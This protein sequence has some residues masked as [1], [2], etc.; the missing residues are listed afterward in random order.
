MIQ[1]CNRAV[2]IHRE[3]GATEFFQS[4]TLQKKIE[5]SCRAAGL[6]ETW[7]AEDI[8]LSVEFSLGE[9]GNDKVFTNSEIDAIVVKILQEAGLATVAAHYRHLQDN[10]EAEITFTPLAIKE[11]V[12]RYLHVDTAQLDHIVEKVTDAGQKLLLKDTSPTLILELAKHYMD[13]RSYLSNA[14]ES[15]ISKNLHSCPW[16]ISR[17]EILQKI[18]GR[19]STLVSSDVLKVAGVSRLFPSIRIEIAFANFAKASGLVA[20]VTDFIIF[21]YL[22]NLAEAID[23]IITIGK[24]LALQLPEN[25]T[26]LPVYLKFTDAPK[27]TNDWL[28]GNWNES[29]NCFEELVT[30][31]KLLLH[32]KVFSYS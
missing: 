28:G 18:S 23:N 20:P 10:P 16:L 21:S 7:I 13:D 29:K 27:F 12:S 25:N 4:E 22:A 5:S 3:N 17:D 30:E 24:E 1:L 8:A 32:N 19:T 2:L 15:S 14:P 6:H 31:L 9:L 26:N 11:I